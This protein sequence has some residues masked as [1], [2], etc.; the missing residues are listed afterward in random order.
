MRRTV[1]LLAIAALLI[2][3][4]D[5]KA[6][7]IDFNSPTYTDGEL[8]GQDTWTG[9][10]AHTGGWEVK[11]TAG[12]GYVESV[13]N[14]GTK[15][16]TFAMTTAN[17]GLANPNPT[18]IQTLTFD[19]TLNASSG[20]ARIATFDFGRD[21]SEYTPVGNWDIYESGNVSIRYN[22]AN[23]PGPVVTHTFSGLLSDGVT[24]KITF[25]VDYDNLLVRMSKDNSVI[26]NAVSGNVNGWIPFDDTRGT[27]QDPDAD[28][29]LGGIR[30][31]TRGAAG[32]IALDNIVFPIPEPASLVLLGLGGLVMLKRRG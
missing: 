26:S 7:T 2:F 13:S 8:L 23:H 9:A 15:I 10:G 27:L 3:A 24:A 16:A 28:L 30:L 5:A 6:F 32:T 1:T 14:P 4:V 20:T 18:G 19:I 11:N 22:T 25:D 12:D 31:I 21:G 29:N 17:T